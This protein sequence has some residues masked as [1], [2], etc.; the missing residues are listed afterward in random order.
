VWLLPVLGKKSGI[1]NY[2]LPFVAAKGLRR[3][4]NGGIICEEKKE[5]EK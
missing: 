3:K 1:E 5:G 2:H 4:N